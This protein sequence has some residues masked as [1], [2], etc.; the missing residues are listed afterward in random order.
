MGVALDV[1]LRHI[2]VSFSQLDGD[3]GEAVTTHLPGL[4]SRLKTAPSDKRKG[5]LPISSVSAT[6]FSPGCTP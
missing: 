2:S 1:Q 4:N 3:P 5:L 6:S